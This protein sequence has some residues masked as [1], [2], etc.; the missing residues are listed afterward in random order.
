MLKID[1]AR[2]RTQVFPTLTRRIETGPV[3]RDGS[4][5]Q[6]GGKRLEENSV[7]TVEVNSEY[8]LRDGVAVRILL[9]SMKLS[10]ET[11]AGDDKVSGN[12]EN[13]L[14]RKLKNSKL[15]SIKAYASSGF[16]I[17]IERS[18]I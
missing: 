14:I 1:L 4:L 10:R 17:T 15:Y 8:L 18:F 7:D 9:S 11:A 3:Q 16:I 6:G 12:V 2:F 13:T 5:K